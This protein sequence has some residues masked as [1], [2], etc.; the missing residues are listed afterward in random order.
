MTFTKSK[1]DALTGKT[2]VHFTLQVPEGEPEFKIVASSSGVRFDGRSPEFWGQE[3][4]Q[5]LAQTIGQAFTEYQKLRPKFATNMS[6][7]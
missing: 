3:G 7:H 1:V 5:V 6:G 2:E 4:A